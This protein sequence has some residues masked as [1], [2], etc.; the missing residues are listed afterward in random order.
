MKQLSTSVTMS[1]LE[2]VEFINSQRK[3]GEAELQH[4]HFLEKVTKVFSEETSAKFSADLP[5][6][7]GRPRK[8]YRFPKREACLMAMSYSYELQAKVFDRMTDLE[9]AKLPVQSYSR[10]DANKEFRSF[11]GIA[12][13]IGL[14][15]NVAAISAN[16]AVTTATGINVLNLLGQVHLI[17]QDQTL[18]FTP[19]QLGERLGISGMAFNRELERAGL[20]YREISGL[21]P[22]DKAAGLYRILDTGKR[23]GSG[24][25]VQ[26]IK[27]S[28]TVLELI[29]VNNVVELKTHK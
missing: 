15:K 1:S 29:N 14:D 2:L 3:E 5:D 8:G 10:V 6:S 9:I 27:W 28:D 18:Y 24:T 21:V 25:M 19:T 22:T 16:Q 23:H 12:K 26:Q 20:Q 7:Y 13:L 17:S 11:F 4:K